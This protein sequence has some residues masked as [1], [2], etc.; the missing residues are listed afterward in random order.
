MASIDKRPDGRWRARW[1]EY[2]SGPQKSKHF[3]RKVDA[4]RF[5]VDVEHRLLSGS[6]TPRSAGQVTVTDYA[7]EWTGRRHWRPATADRVER[8]LRLHILPTLGQRPLASLRRG[9]IEEWAARLPL[10]ASSAQA[11]AGTLTAMLSAA[12]ED[13][14]I[15]HNPVSGA[16][17][18][19]ADKAPIV[20]VTV[21]QVHD[22][23]AGTPEHV[24]VAVVAAAGTGLR[25]GE[26]FGALCRPDR[27]PRPR[28]AGRSAALDPAARGGCAP[29]TE[30]T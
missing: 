22:V 24:R 27:L 1:R 14:R 4:Q 9:H 30:V 2:P 10:A 29:T 21:E 8:E 19:R 6:Y 7:T 23:A 28:A 20:P 18:P 15:P 12:V 26:L 5:L 25:Q 16:R 17:L 11:V 13:E 3:A